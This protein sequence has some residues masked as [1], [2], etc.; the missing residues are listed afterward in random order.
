LEELFAG[1]NIDLNAVRARLK[2]A[3][4]EA[5]LPIK[6]R[7]MTYNSRLATE[8]GKWAEEMGRGDEYHNAVFKAYFAEGLNISDVSVLKE[9]CKWIGL[10]PLEAEKAIS[11]R[12]YKKAVNEDWEYS[13]RIGVSAV[14]TFLF[15]NRIVVGAQPY[16]MLVKLV[17]R[18]IL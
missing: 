8:L 18:N 16:E 9:L 12:N 10:N 15:D 1:R 13:L 7:N 6:D 14:P 2:M 11:N 5:N 3:A 4:D 17:N